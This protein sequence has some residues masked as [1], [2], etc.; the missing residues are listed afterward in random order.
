LLSS[1]LKLEN[2][3][4]NLKLRAKYFKT[5]VSFFSS[6][7]SYSSNFPNCFVTL[8]LNSLFK[9]FEAKNF[10]S[11]N[12]IKE[13]HSLFVFGNSVNARVN[14]V[15]INIYLKKIFPKSKLFSL[16]KSANSA[17][18]HFLNVKIVNTKIL[19]KAQNLF[20]WGLEDNLFIHKL[21]LDLKKH[22]S[23]IF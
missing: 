11:L 10:F 12:F 9:F 5:Q 19:Q 14:A 2:I 8:N 3:V 23:C 17:G 4:L 15:D 13:F 16:N 22:A 7:F 21:F 1:N 20:M 6:G 18:L